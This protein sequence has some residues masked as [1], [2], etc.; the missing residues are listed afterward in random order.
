MRKSSEQPPQEGP[1]HGM[2]NH[3]LQHAHDARTVTLSATSYQHVDVSVHTHS[4]KATAQ[5][6][7]AVTSDMF[8]HN[9]EVLLRSAMS[10]NCTSAEVVAPYAS[11]RTFLLQ[12]T[13]SNW[14]TKLRT[15]NNA[16]PHNRFDFTCSMIIAVCRFLYF[17]SA[18]AAEPIDAC[19]GLVAHAVVSSVGHTP[20]CS[21]ASKS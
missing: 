9:Q 6:V 18:A 16:H 20:I 1:A 7:R 19:P 12:P 10:K 21:R 11:L 2:R 5:Y 4:N 15:L 3:I 13:C 17:N 14:R 8:S